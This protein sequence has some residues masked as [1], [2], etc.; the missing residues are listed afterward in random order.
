IEPKEGLTT[1][2]SFL[3]S[4]PITLSNEP[5]S[6]ETRVHAKLRASRRKGA[7]SDQLSN[8]IP[9][10]K[11]ALI[12]LL[13]IGASAELR[14]KRQWFGGFGWPSTVVQPTVH[15]TSVQ[16]PVVTQEIQQ[17]VYQTQFATPI[18]QNHEHVV[19]TPV[20][21]HIQHTVNVPTPVVD[22]VVI[23]PKIIVP[24]P[25]TTKISVIQRAKRQW[26]GGFSGFGWGVPAVATATPAVAVAT[27]VPTVTVAPTQHVHT[28]IVNPPLVQQVVRPVVH[29]QVV[30]PVVHT[31]STVFRP[32]VHEVHSNVYVPQIVHV[33]PTI[34]EPVV[35]SV[36][37]AKPSETKI[38]VIQR[39]KRQVVFGGF[40]YYSGFAYAS[41][42][43]V[44]A[45]AAVVAPVVVPKTPAN[46]K[47]SVIQRVKRLGQGPGK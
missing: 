23:T 18:V 28:N 4:F 11:V 26:F 14:E 8:L 27:A 36:V 1:S 43:V 33:K 31:Q 5:S 20:Y 46:T 34:I 3:S 30:Q 37:P 19:D 22:P 24:K 10:M 35:E 39:H 40:P 41:P 16:Q 42:A 6:R 7:E 38:S 25:S 2:S 44:S 17:P 47:I 13:A 29:T 9:S 45:P 32:V 21:K 15:T 12:A